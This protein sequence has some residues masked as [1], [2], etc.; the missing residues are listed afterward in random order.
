M[1]RQGQQWNQ[2][3]RWSFNHLFSIPSLTPH[4][5]TINHIFRVGRLNKFIFEFV[6]LQIFVW[7]III[8]SLRR[9][10]RRE[11]RRVWSSW[12]CI[13]WRIC[14]S[15]MRMILMGI[16]QFI[17]GKKMRMIKYVRGDRKSKRGLGKRR[18]IW[19]LACR[20]SLLLKLIKKIVL[21][22]KIITKI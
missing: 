8:Y 15:N 1:N 16:I 10:C 19:C 3:I 5:F 2:N 22:K 6:I 11:S 18:G 13:G 7:K 4:Y 12:K 14:Y 21:F 17:W 9:F 20:S